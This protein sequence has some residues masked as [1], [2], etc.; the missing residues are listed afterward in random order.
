MAEG[1]RAYWPYYAVFVVAWCI[2]ALD[3]RLFVSRRSDMLIPQL[4]DFTKTIV[5]SYVLTLF[6]FA[7]LTPGGLPRRFVFAFGIAV[8][9]FLTASRT[10]M[11]LG[12]WRLRRRGYNYRR[13]VVVGSN[14][15]SAHVADVIRSHEHYGYQI[16]GFLDDD[17]RRRHH[18]E[19]FS[20]PY[21]GPVSELERRLTDEVIDVV[22]ISLPVRSHYE[23]IQ[24]IAH[25]CE[26]VGVPVRLIAD[27]FPLRIATSELMKVG[28]IPVL[29]LSP[30]PEFH[31]QWALRRMTDV[32]VSSILLVLLAPVFVV[33]AA[34]IRVESRG[35][36][37]V[38][39]PRMALRS[40]KVFNLIRFRTTLPDGK[41]GSRPSGRLG[42]FLRE[43]GLDELP[44]L[45]NI[46]RGQMSLHEP[47][48]EA[49]TAGARGPEA[50]AS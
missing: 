21:W 35:P 7:L 44:M 3:Q 13:I 11:R 14:A 5:I 25:L 24:S 15:R 42:R 8:L 30:A 49:V 16:I 32:V 31:T 1:L 9:L 50:A 4:F 40:G 26:G 47:R 2:Q 36:V 17:E 41:G 19:A 6:I 28:D 18:L 12:L 38:L 22:Y 46:W 37:F 27:L 20:I 33:L 10:V 43:Y 29:S 39:E 34:L 23:T 48:P 45:A